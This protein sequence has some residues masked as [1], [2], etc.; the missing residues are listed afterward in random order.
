MDP[1]LENIQKAKY[2]KN[3]AKKHFY[4][5]CK[6][7]RKEYRKTFI[8]C[9]VLL[10]LMILFNFG[11]VFLTNVSVT[12]EKIEAG[13]IIKLQE[14]NPAQVVLSKV[15]QEQPYELHPEWQNLMKAFVNQV[16]LWLILICAV[17]AGRYR[18]TT[19]EG[20]YAYLALIVFRSEE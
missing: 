20:L 15:T 1:Y 3:L 4:S 10:I 17:L 14:V 2:Y 5:R 9:D 13:H 11:A 12:R 7:F 16:F 8:F 19:E 18:T 6:D